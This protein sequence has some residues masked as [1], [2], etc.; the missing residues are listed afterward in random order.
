[1]CSARDNVALPTLGFPIRESAG[2]WPFSASPRLIA[3][4][5]ALHRLL[6]PRHPPC[7]LNILTVIL[8]RA[9]Q[10][11]PVIPV[12]LATVQFSRSEKRRSTPYGRPDRGPAPP[13]ACRSLKTQQHAS[14]ILPARS[15]AV[16]PA[17]SGRRSSGRSYSRR[18]SRSSEAPVPRAAPVVDDPADDRC[19]F[20]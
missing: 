16:R 5:H 19:P 11:R 15:A 8:G 4:V 12:S 20:G 6:V 2:H 13:A 18:A 14:R 17:R 10:L 3:A 7:A 9:F 1:M